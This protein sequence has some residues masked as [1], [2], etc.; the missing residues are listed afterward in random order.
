MNGLET[1]AMGSMFVKYANQVD[2]RIAIGELFRKLV[3]IMNVGLYQLQIGQQDK[4]V[5]VRFPIPGQDFQLIAVSD[6]TVGKSAADKAA[7]AKDAQFSD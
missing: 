2:D 7:S 1:R 3:D 4:V 5:F 6:E